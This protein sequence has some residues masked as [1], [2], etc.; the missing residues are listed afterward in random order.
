M[1]PPPHSFPDSCSNSRPH[2]CTYGSPYAGP[3]QFR[4]DIRAHG[5]APDG[6]TYGRPYG[7]PD[8]CSDA[9][10][11]R[12]GSKRKAPRVLSLRPLIDAMHS[13]ICRREPIGM[14]VEPFPVL[15]GGAFDQL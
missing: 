2:S 8:S 5:G 6:G 12:G 13:C 11:P 4:R 14:R 1:C 3:D 15:P 10:P 7:G 9:R